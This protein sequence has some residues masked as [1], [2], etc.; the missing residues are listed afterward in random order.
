MASVKSPGDPIGVD[1]SGWSPSKIATS[2]TLTF[3]SMGNPYTP[4][5]VAEEPKF[6][7]YCGHPLVSGKVVGREYGPTNGLMAGRWSMYGCVQKRGLLY[8]PR[9]VRLMCKL[10][11]LSPHTLNILTEKFDE[12]DETWEHWSNIS[13]HHWYKN[14][15]HGTGVW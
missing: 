7:K 10:R 4:A 14:K 2:G 3:P 1:I 6:C 11:M 5:A 8:Q 12:E 9:L 15:K 13:L